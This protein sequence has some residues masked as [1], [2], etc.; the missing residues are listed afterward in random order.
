MGFEIRTLDYFWKGLLLSSLI[1]TFFLVVMIGSAYLIKARASE[2]KRHM[3][4]QWLLLSLSLVTGLALVFFGDQE[5]MAGC[6]DKFAQKNSLLTTTRWIA[7]SWILSTSIL[8]IKDIAQC[9]WIIYKSRNLKPVHDLYLRNILSDLQ[10]KMNIARKI[11]LCSTSENV[12]PFA[13]GL[14]QPRIVIPKN[15]FTDLDEKTIQSILAHELIHL[16]DRDSLGL[17]AELFCRRWVF[18]HPLAYWAG[19][20]YRRILETS[21]DEKAVYQA[22]IEEKVYLKALLEVASWAQSSE[23]SP[24]YLAASR[25]FAEMKERIES[26]TQKRSTASW[27]IPALMILPFISLAV[28]MA[29]AKSMIYQNRDVTLQERMMCTQV[30]YEKIIESWLKIETK[31]NKCE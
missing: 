17:F 23:P 12:S 24:L 30:E 26:L 5:L 19:I 25:G 10:N 13:L 27:K 11:K 15:L 18:W 20:L 28:S 29:E 2:I 3:N 4:L 6:F 9:A 22:Q 8:A 31:T 16:Q 14:W 1:S 7:G 21:A